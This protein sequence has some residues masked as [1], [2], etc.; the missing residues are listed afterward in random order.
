MALL[1]SIEGELDPAEITVINEVL[2]GT[3]PNFKGVDVNR[4]LKNFIPIFATDE[5]GNF[6]L[7]S[8]QVNYYQYFKGL[9]SKTTSFID[10]YYIISDLS[11][12]KLFIEDI[13]IKLTN[14][15]ID[16]EDGIII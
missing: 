12:L 1:D 7:K 4:K 6:I 9:D 11:L 15:S 2:V 16:S 13:N 5:Q 14:L 8:I 10:K 3:D